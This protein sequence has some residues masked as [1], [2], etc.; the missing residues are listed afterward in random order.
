M[1]KNIIKIAAVLGTMAVGI[2]AFGAHGLEEILV[3]NGRVGTFQTAVNYHFYHVLAL[4][5]VGILANYK[6]SKLLSYCSLLFTL[7]IVIFSGS[8][9]ILSLTNITLLGAITPLGGVCFIA[10]WILLF[11][12]MKKAS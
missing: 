4:L 6:P 11:W 9:Y 12:A 1:S 8:L 5:A 3:T 10:G 7:G 2:G